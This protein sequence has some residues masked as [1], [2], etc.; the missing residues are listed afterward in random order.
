MRCI[1]RMDVLNI[2]FNKFKK[3]HG[4]L[5]DV[6]FIWYMLALIYIRAYFSCIPY[7]NYSSLDNDNNTNTSTPVML[8]TITSESMCHSA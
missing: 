5:M 8:F 4:L 6:N 7:H 1:F 2:I 3:G